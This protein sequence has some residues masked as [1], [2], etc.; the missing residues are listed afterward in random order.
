MSEKMIF[1]IGM[2]RSGTSLV[3]NWLQ[4]C[5]LDMG[6]KLVGPNFSNPNGHF[7]DT[8]FVEYHEALLSWNKQSMYVKKEAQLHVPK[9][10]K[11]QAE[12][13]VQRRSARSQQWGLKQP[14][15]TVFL[16]MWHSILPFGHY[17]AP[18]R[19]YSEVVHSLYQRACGKIKSLEKTEPT[20]AKALLAQF[21]QAKDVSCNNYLSVWIR[22]NQDL[23]NH[24]REV[25]P[26]KCL[27]FQPRNL[28]QL[29]LQIFTTI[30]KD[31]GFEL[32]YSSLQE[33]YQSELL[34]E[35]QVQCTN[36]ELV[37]EAEALWSNLLQISIT[38]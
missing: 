13:F 15:A 24:Y 14:R 17:L 36:T 1:I 32:N 29:D 18:I 25:G 38:N 22:H 21:Q 10:Y 7:E 3:A 28:P 6:E 23:L 20:K 2:H 4:A 19:H 9:L 11:M 27:I 37:Q 34:S 12:K 5:G 26:Q 31:W 16:D 30:S 33:I 35:E 8:L